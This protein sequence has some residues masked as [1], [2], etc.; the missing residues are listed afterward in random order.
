MSGSGSD[1]HAA[2]YGADAGQL[3]ERIAV[4]EANYRHTIDRIEH[5]ADQMESVVEKTDEMH[6][7]LLQAKGGRWVLLG[8]AG[9]IGFVMANFANLKWLIQLLL[10]LPK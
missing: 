6:S 2:P 5:M 7:V 10:G 4:L 3:R 1:N 9:L 8:T